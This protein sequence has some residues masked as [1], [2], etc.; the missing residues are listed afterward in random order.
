MYNP[1]L[2][3]FEYQHQHQDNYHFDF[4]N[5]YIPIEKNNDNNEVPS[6]KYD[7][8]KKLSIKYGRLSYY[9]YL[10][11]NWDNIINNIEGEI[12]IQKA[13]DLINLEYIKY[14]KKNISAI[15]MWQSDNT[16]TFD[17]FY[18]KEIT[19]N[20]NFT[21][22]LMFWSLPNI[23]FEERYEIVSN[24]IKTLYPKCYKY[25]LKIY[26]TYKNSINLDVFDQCQHINNSNILE[27]SQLVLNSNSIYLLENQDLN[28]FLSPEMREPH[29]KLQTLKKTLLKS[30]IDISKVILIGSIIFYAFGFRI[31]KDIDGIIIQSKKEKNEENI[32]YLF[33]NIL[34]EVSKLNFL[35][36]G[37]LG[38]TY[39]KNHWDK[40]N[41]KMYN[42]FGITSYCQLVTDPKCHFYFQGLKF[43]IPDIEIAARF[44]R[45]NVKDV[46]DLM[47]FSIVNSEIFNR[48][49]RLTFNKIDNNQILQNPIF[50]NNY[51]IKSLLENICNKYPKKNIISFNQLFVKKR[52]PQ[53]QSILEEK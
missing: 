26:F 10:I 37:M 47:M 6:E 52:Y 45:K 4:N 2:F 3:D 20:F 5:Q 38:T 49:I 29:F 13:N 23:N 19:S 7:I 21:F 31:P 1:E 32:N 12:D 30:Q 15:I 33:E 18:S 24:K 40:I 27:F 50:L 22:N 39:W 35:D 48:S 42:Y 11:E 34:D 44:N 9:Y 43:C 46:S 51:D 36:F 41:L 14:S 28:N 53:Y 25:S 8:I 16:N 17:F